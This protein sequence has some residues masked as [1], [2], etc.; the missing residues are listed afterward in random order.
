M[1]D[2][3]S[4]MEVCTGVEKRGFMVDNLSMREVR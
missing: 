3:L 2:N 1:D 4:V